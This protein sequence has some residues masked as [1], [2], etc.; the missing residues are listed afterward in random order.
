MRL[1]ACLLLCALGI[2]V[3]CADPSPE[4]EAF[5]RVPGEVPVVRQAHQTFRVADLSPAVIKILRGYVWRTPDGSLGSEVHGFTFD[6]N[7][8]GKLEYFISTIYG[9]SGGP[10]YMILTEDQNGWEV[11]GGFQGSLHVL[12]AATGWPDLVTTSRG[13]G[14]IFAKVHHLFR[15]GRY[16]QTSIEHYHRG[17]I[18][19]EKLP[20]Q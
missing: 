14:G 13:G 3:V 11:I 15:G 18:T 16:I 8:D 20:R 9:G 5:L 10:D 17:V 1:H 4:E 2:R 7:K 12:P 6:L 19:I